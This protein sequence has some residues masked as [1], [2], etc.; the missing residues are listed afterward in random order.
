V[1]FI[2][3]S[4]IEKK[5]IVLGIV[6]QAIKITTADEMEFFICVYSRDEVFDLMTKQWQMRAAYF[7]RQSEK[8]PRYFTLPIAIK[9]CSVLTGGS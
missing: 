5:G 3:V 2:N 9:S 1:A 4:S 8:F 7:K 6:Q